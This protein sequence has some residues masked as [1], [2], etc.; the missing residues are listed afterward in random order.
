LTARAIPSVSQWGLALFGMLTLIVA[1]LRFG[2]SLKAG[3]R[4][5]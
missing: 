3:R 2:Q 5:R 1:K 4:R